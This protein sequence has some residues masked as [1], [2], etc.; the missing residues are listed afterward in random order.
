MTGVIAL[1][2][3]TRIEI[4]SN[5]PGPNEKGHVVD[6]WLRVA[7]PWA[8]VVDILPSRSERVAEAIDIAA[9]PCRIRMRYR[10]DID[11]SMRV[12]IGGRMLK[13]IAGPAELGRRQGTEIL[14]E[15]L[16]TMGAGG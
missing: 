12:K 16:S 13:I 3:D 15:E 11:A 2:L 10:D 14:A 4:W 6:R 5:T 7:A 9:R 8:E 1:K